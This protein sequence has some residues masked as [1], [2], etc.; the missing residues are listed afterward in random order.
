MAPLASKNSHLNNASFCFLSAR[1]FP[2]SFLFRRKSLPLP[3]FFVFK[4]VFP[5]RTSMSSSIYYT[6]STA[7]HS[8]ARHSAISRH[9]AAN[10]VRAHQSAA[11]QASRESW[12]EPRARM[13][14]RYL[15]LAAFSKRTRKSTSARPTKKHIP[16][17]KAA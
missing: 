12:R 7:Q 17:T 14:S 16:L 1:R 10:S 13:L 9:K 11:T 6:A 15:Q 4:G 2:F 3:F 5:R 8:T